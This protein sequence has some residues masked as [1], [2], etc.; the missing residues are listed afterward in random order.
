[1]KNS[2]KNYKE[3]SCVRY[4][5]KSSEED[6]K[7]SLKANRVLKSIA[8]LGLAL[9]TSSL[10]KFEAADRNTVKYHLVWILGMSAKYLANLK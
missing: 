4:A 5:R 8:T 9:E 1:M 3:L 10:A 6:R 7:E 2:Q